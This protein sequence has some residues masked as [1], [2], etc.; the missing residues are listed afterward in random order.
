MTKR[1]CHTIH[2]ARTMD[3]TRRRSDSQRQRQASRAGFTLVEIL[4]GLAISAMLLAAI[5]V[6]FN[7]SVMNYAENE[8]MYQTINNGRQALTRM[9]SE[10]RTGSEVSFTAAA[11]LC[12]FFTADGAGTRY[13]FTGNQLRLQKNGG[14]WHV[15]CDNVTAATFTKTPVDSGDDSKSVQISLTVRSGDFER[16]LSAAAVMRRNL[17]F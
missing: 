10:L 2:A 1:D 12:E 13:E 8:Q 6:A 17:P 15:L 3:R 16:T 5:A 11:N 4:I 14:T 9:T 7:A